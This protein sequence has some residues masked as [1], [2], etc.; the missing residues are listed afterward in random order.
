MTS[1]VASLPLGLAP[2]LSAAGSLL[3]AVLVAG[4][5]A[6]VIVGLELARA[7]VARS[8]DVAPMEVRIL[9]LG[10]P[11]AP[12]TPPAAPGTEAIVALTAPIVGALLGAAL[13]LAS[14]AVEG[15]GS[16]VVTALHWALTWLGSGVLVV[17]AFISLPLLPLDGGRVVRA[18][19][20][21]VTG[22]L[23]RATRVTTAIGRVFGY[24]VLGAGLV[25][26]FVGELLV[27]LWLLLLGWLATRVARGS[28]DRARLEE[29]TAGLVVGDALDSE[30]P[31]IGPAVT[32]DALLTR[33]EQP[34][35]RG[36]YPV[37]VDG[38]L[39]GVV[40]VS[41]ITRRARRRA[42]ELRAADVMV[43]VE[44]L[45][46][47][48]PDDPLLEAVI[49]IEGGHVD[50]LPVVADDDP[51]RIVGLVTRD[52][53]VERLRARQTLQAARTGQAGRAARG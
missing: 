8:R 51:S 10:L 4:L 33:D 44:R 28:A 7:L 24:L 25:A 43:P 12:E 45:R 3:V 48:R 41:R 42:S 39:V 14:R 9:T 18:V 47:L 40:F 30:P 32:L 5:L 27:G 50:A 1:L 34:D 22:D 6:I 46:A 53:V 20:W 23:A 52:R 37:L 31:S 49:R 13:V 38:R 21:R 11:P 17:A 2:R 36:V 19:A 29:L 26:T 35:T 16:E 15:V